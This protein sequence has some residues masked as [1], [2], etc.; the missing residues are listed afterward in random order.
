[1]IDFPVFDVLEGGELA[2]S[3]HPFTS[4]VDVEEMR[5]RPG[6]AIAQAYDLVLNG[7]ELGSGSVRIHDPTF[8]KR[9]SR[10]SE[11]PPRDAERRFGWFVKALRYGT[12]PHAGFAL[13][14]DR[15]LAILQQE[16]SIRDVIPFPKTQTGIDPMTGSPTAVDAAQLAE[17]GVELMADRRPG[18]TRIRKMDDLFAAEREARQ[19]EVA[20]LAARMRPRSLDEVAGQTHLVGTGCRLCIDG[21]GRAAGIDDPVGSAR[22]RKDHAGPSGGRR[23]R[24]PL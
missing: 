3:H 17:L 10:F 18:E 4:P 9:S 14:V 2:P 16:A 11:S 19:A 7:S 13:G 15:L 12:P 5:E 6:Q 21:R 22:H 20:P 23:N 1:M 8:S 24:R